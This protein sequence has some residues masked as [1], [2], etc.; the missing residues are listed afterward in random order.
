MMGVVISIKQARF[1]LDNLLDDVYYK[2][3]AEKAKRTRTPDLEG[4]T[5]D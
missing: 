1:K 3:V 4:K 2:D 5:N